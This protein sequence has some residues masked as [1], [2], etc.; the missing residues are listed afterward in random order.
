MLKTFVFALVWN[1]FKI[2][3]NAGTNLQISKHLL[4]IFK[5]VENAFTNFKTFIFKRFFEHYRKEL[6]IHIP[7]IPTTERRSADETNWE[8]CW[9]TNVNYR[10]YVW[11]RPVIW[12]NT[13]LTC[14]TRKWRNGFSPFSTSLHSVR[15]TLWNIVGSHDTH[16][17]VHTRD[18]F[19]IRSLVFDSLC[20]N[21]SQQSTSAPERFCE[22]IFANLSF[23]GFFLRKSDRSPKY[24]MV[25]RFCKAVSWLAERLCFATG[26]LCNHHISTCKAKFV[27]ILGSL[28]AFFSFLR[29]LDGQQA[30]SHIARYRDEM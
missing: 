18:M 26:G 2:K 29:G 13:S 19:A 21:V 15:Q 4:K 6:Y 20:F 23:L 3:T 27:T 11:V 5:N 17:F 8:H 9:C 7:W 10:T 12:M 28:K 30:M 25:A 22:S 16:N 24:K 1:T 14:R